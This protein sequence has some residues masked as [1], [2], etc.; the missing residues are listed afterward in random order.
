MPPSPRLSKRSTMV[1]Y[2]SETMRVMAQNVIDSTARMLSSVSGSA[3]AP[4]KASLKAYSG[5]VP[6]SPNTIP[7]A[8]SEYLKRF[9]YDTIGHN[10]QIMMNLVRMVGADR[11]MLGSDYCYDMGHERPVDVVD[12]LKELSAGERGLILGQTAARLLN[13]GP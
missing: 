5:L 11:V 4:E 2:F 12:R 7:R 9:T 1:R 3:C 10:D 6:M 8:P 13:V